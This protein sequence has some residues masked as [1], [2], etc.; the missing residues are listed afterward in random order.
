MG[1]LGAH[2]L[3]QHVWGH[4]CAAGGGQEASPPACEWLTGS[5]SQLLHNVRENLL[6]SFSE[7]LPEMKAA[8]K[9]CQLSP[10]VKNIIYYV[11]CYHTQ[12]TCW[13]MVSL[14]SEIRDETL[15]TL[16]TA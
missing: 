10:L 9:S 12:K 1:C 7:Q 13:K 16:I 11:Y 14:Q 4:L 5:S 6:F 2:I 15:E 8:Q 3:S